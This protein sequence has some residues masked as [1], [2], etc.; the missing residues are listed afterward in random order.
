MQIYAI[1]N[2]YFPAFKYAPRSPTYISSQCISLPE[3]DFKTGLFLNKKMD[4]EKFFADNNW[5]GNHNYSDDCDE[6]DVSLSYH[7]SG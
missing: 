7:Q 1:L 4:N 3:G 6:E 5:R 2:F